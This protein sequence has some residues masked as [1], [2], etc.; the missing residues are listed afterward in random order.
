MSTHTI[1]LLDAFS[2]LAVLSDAFVA[3]P[4]VQ[5]DARL[6]DVEG[7]EGR[8]DDEGNGEGRSHWESLAESD[9]ND[10]C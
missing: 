3:L 1:G 5:F 7:E 10:V 8:G 4:C 6:H 9:C 2:L